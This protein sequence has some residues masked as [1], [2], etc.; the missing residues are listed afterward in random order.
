MIQYMLSA[1]GAYQIKNKQFESKIMEKYNQEELQAIIILEKYQ[2]LRQKL[3][4]QI[5]GKIL[6]IILIN[7][8]PAVPVHF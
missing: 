1:K 8:L 6:M 7:F 5:K 4:L 2:T 3:L